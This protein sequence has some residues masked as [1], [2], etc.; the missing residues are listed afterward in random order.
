VALAV[1]QTDTGTDTDTETQTRDTNTE[2]FAGTMRIGVSLCVCVLTE[3]VPS[4]LATGRALKHFNRH[5][6]RSFSH[7][8]FLREPPVLGTP[9]I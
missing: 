3:V 2:I 9:P 7:F 6:D 4:V 1:S 8:L 5:H